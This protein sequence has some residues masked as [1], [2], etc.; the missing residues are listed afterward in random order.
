METRYAHPR[1]ST[2]A[3]AREGYAGRRDERPLVSGRTLDVV[4][5]MLTASE[6][7][8]TDRKM[9]SVS[10]PDPS[11]CATPGL[12]TCRAPMPWSVSPLVGKTIDWRAGW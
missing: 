11:L 10:A 5:R 12:L 6:E 7:G 3:S 1:K 9:S 2:G 8:V 4:A